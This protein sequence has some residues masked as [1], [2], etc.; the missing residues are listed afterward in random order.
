M[1][2]PCS[3]SNK[4]PQE[5]SVCCRQEGAHVPVTLPWVLENVLYLQI[6]GG[7][8]ICVCMLRACEWISAV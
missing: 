8:F 4:A 7:D 2:C 1:G 6:S 5:T 3:D